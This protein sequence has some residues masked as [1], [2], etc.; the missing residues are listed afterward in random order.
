[1]VKMSCCLIY[2]LTGRNDYDESNTLRSMK[3]V[4]CCRASRHHNGVE[5]EKNILDRI[6]GIE[7]A[8]TYEIEHA[9]KMQYAENCVTQIT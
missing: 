8:T 9:Q 4:E 6:I 1:M 2:S 7:T 3:F 5:I